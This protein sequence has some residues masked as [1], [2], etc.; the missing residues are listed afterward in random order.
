M[1][2]VTFDVSQF[3][4]ECRVGPLQRRILWI[5]GLIGAVEGFDAQA[6]GYIAPTLMADWHLPPGA[7]AP[8]FSLSLFG[9]MLGALFI[10]PFADRVGRRPVLLASLVVFGASTLLTALARDL[11]TLTALRF[12]TGI[13]L[14]GAMPNAVAL[15]AEFMPRRRRAFLV[16]L[17]F[18]GFNIGSMVGGIVSAQYVATLGWQAVFVVGGILPLV[19]APVIFFR[20]PESIAF[21]ALS[22]APREKILVLLR[23]IDPHVHV[24]E[25]AP[26][27]DVGAHLAQKIAVNELFGGGRAAT[28]LLIWLIFFMSLLDIYLL[29]SWLPTSLN[30]G[31]ATVRM[32]IIAGV[33]LQLGSVLG[34]LPIGLAVDRFGAPL[35]MMCAYLV[36]AVCIACIG[37]FASNIALT[38]AAAFGA[39]FGLIGG[40]A[41][42]N[43]LAATSYPTQLRS[44]G[45]GWALGIGRV[46]SIIGPLLGGALMTAHVPV[47]KLF[48]MAA[49]PAAIAALALVVLGWMRGQI[50]K[51][52]LASHA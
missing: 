27:R 15:T 48:A 14:G 45:V 42:A 1:R 39:G 33:V 10:A 5:C 44:T 7:L 17:M 32:A 8:V 50:G 25:D 21:L 29:V 26:L 16:M 2:S 51:R 20:L 13:G 35:V 19:L 18:N 40:Q 28:T 3:L 24:E 22:D 31:G 38:L 41:A 37:V 36:G 9:L 52:P 23:R 43:A 6:V 4:D 30:A 34:C 46:G 49:V 47:P 12:L 11:G